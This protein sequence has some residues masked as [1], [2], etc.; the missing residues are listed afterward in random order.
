MGFTTE[1]W[2]CVCGRS[3]LG[4]TPVPDEIVAAGCLRDYPVVPFPTTTVLGDSLVR[5]AEP[6]P[7]EV[8]HRFD[9][10]ATAPAS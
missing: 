3:R 9:I 6:A 10:D 5:S 7:P 2:G 1:P 4:G 8:V